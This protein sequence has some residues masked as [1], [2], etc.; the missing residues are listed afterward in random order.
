MSCATSASSTESPA[1]TP[2]SAAKVSGSHT[3]PGAGAVSPIVRSVLTV[4]PSAYTTPV[5][6]HVAGGDQ[7]HRVAE[8]GVWADRPHRHRRGPVD[9]ERVES[10]GDGSRSRRIGQPGRRRPGVDPRAG[11]RAHG[12]ECLLVE[13][14]IGGGLRDERRGGRRQRQHGGGHADRQ[15]PQGTPGD[16][17][18]SAAN[19][20]IDRPAGAGKAY[21]IEHR[22]GPYAAS[23][24]VTGSA[25]PARG[26]PHWA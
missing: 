19:Q 7:R 17:R 18:R 14:A 25:S 26:L 2:S 21:S 1:L 9:V 23:P 15:S 3:A 13:G 5:A 6:A 20:R 16:E 11:R 24:T 10:R 22:R 12:G 4:S 8:P